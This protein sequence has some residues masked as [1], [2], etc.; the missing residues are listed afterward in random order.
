[1]FWDPTRAIR[2][3]IKE[4]LEQEPGSPGVIVSA[5]RIGDL[6]DREIDLAKR[7]EINLR[8]NENVDE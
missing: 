6:V 3:D 8:Y 4:T 1:M 5:R 2:N 7:D